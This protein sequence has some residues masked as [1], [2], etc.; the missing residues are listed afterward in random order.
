MHMPGCACVLA[1][2]VLAGSRA[3][4]LGG[5]RAA[6]ARALLGARRGGGRG[7][8]SPRSCRRFV[9]EIPDWPPS[10]GNAAHFLR[11][12]APGLRL[13]REGGLRPPGAECSGP[14]QGRQCV[15]QGPQE[16][17]KRP[18]LFKSYKY[19]LLIL[20]NRCIQHSFIM[21]H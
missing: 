11:P 6:L 21:W 17:R 10:Q 16:S 3:W 5:L 15:W 2:S 14:P 4:A 19:L 20:L 13:H 12:P 8:R 18:V 1:G 7:R 9:H